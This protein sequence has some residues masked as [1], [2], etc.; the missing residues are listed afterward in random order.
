MENPDL[1]SKCLYQIYHQLG[2]I[3]ILR[4]IS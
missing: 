2:H 1:W 4:Y 3:D